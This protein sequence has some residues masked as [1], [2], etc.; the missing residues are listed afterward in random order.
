MSRGYNRLL[1]GGVQTP[2]REHRQSLPI[3]I[4]E[5][6]DKGCT[7]MAKMTFGR[8][9]QL[10]RIMWAARHPDMNQPVREMKD[11]TSEEIQAIYER[12]GIQRAK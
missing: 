7:R 3:T 6:T 9:N 8:I 12:N 2:K 10:R 4:R 11:M 5:K 1:Y